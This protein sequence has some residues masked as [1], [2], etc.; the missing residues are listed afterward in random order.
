ME[1]VWDSEC[2][3]WHSTVSLR[4]TTYYYPLT[5][6]ISHAYYQ[7]GCYVFKWL[8]LSSYKILHLYWWCLEAGLK[9]EMRSW[10][11]VRFGATRGQHLNK[12]TAISPGFIKV[13]LNTKCDVCCTQAEYLAIWFKN[14][15]AQRIHPA[16]KPQYFG[17][18]RSIPWTVRS[19]DGW[20][21]GWGLRYIYI[22][23]DSYKWII[24]LVNI[25]VFIDILY[26][27][28]TWHGMN[29]VKW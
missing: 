27:H 21:D 22:H 9:F 20:N 17:M 14:A 5:C 10:Q 18:I 16:L 12:G 2:F 1:N 24:M 13:S 28:S 19:W 7:N 11:I 6:Y 4:S 25:A 23:S 29:M 15:L 8:F 26:W 3:L